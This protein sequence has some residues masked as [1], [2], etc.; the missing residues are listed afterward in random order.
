MKKT[1]LTILALTLCI[2]IASAATKN[3]NIDKSINAIDI[4]A[5][6]NVKYIPSTSAHTTV[7]ITGDANRID[8][9]K[10][11]VSGKT[12]C[13]FPEKQGSMRNKINGVTVTVKAPIVSSIDASAGAS[14]TCTNPIV[15]VS[16]K[17][18]FEASSGASI[19]FSSIHCKSLDIEASSGAE[20]NLKN[21]KADKAEIEASSGASVS[22]PDVNTLDIEADASSG[23]SIKLGGK[24]EKGSLEASSGG[25]IKASRLSVKHLSV[26]RSISGSIKTR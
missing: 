10:V 25:S 17:V 16:R 19:S 26:D 18:E 1:L 9:I 20:I 24:S 7:T 12:L 21:L 5:G 8:R 6:V 11:K 15:S 23:A 22:L 3:V 13:I 2:G 4:C 14:V